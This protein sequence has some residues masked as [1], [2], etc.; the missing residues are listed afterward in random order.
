MSIQ[1]PP[2]LGWVAYLAV[3]ES[4]PQGDEDKLR[5]LSEVWQEAAEEL[6]AISHEVGPSVSGVLEGVAGS[7]AGQFGEFV[8]AFL[9][10]LPQTA[11]SAEQLAELARTTAVELQY[12]KYMI[13]VQLAWMALEI[14]QWALYAPQV[15]PGIVAAGRA[16]VK[17]I[18]RRLAVSI[19]A[20]IGLMTGMDVVVQSLQM[21]MG[22]RTR[23]NVRNTLGMVASG[24]IG[25]V[26]GGA[27]PVLGDLLVPKA[28]N[29]LVG[30]LALGGVT[31]LVT[32]V[33]QDVLLGGKSALAGAFT[34]GAAEAFSGGGRRFRWKK[35]TGRDINSL[36]VRIPDLP[37]PDLSRLETGTPGQ[38]GQLGQLGQWARAFPV[39]RL[40]WLLQVAAMSQ[41]P[42]PT[43]TPS[44]RRLNVRRGASRWR[45]CSP[46]R[47]CPRGVSRRLSRP[48]RSLP[49]R[50]SRSL[51]SRPSRSSPSRSSPSRPSRSP[52]SRPSRSTPSRSSPST[53]G[54]SARTAWTLSARW[55]SPPPTA[56]TRR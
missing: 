13:L 23:W 31:G 2:A 14:T 24:A 15:V 4:W 55:P 18:L 12:A 3:G 43:A 27:V 30:K 47:R 8:A 1:L 50:P 51:P 56:G 20:G 48:S 42:R 6:R 32:T 54:T 38:L 37:D 16:A 29:S 40:C 7:V 49:S 39:S 34:S 22:D 45:S 53:P 28:A 41:S 5:E 17:M 36:D 19:A 26:I 52:P 44:R 10:N 11:K 33:A 25:G 46:S 21:L 35:P 9:R